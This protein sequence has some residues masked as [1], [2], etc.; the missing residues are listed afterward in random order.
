MTATGMSKRNSF[1]VT[2]GTLRRDAASYVQREAD[3]LLYDGLKQNKFCYVLTWRQMG[4]SS[5]MVRSGDP[6]RL[7]SRANSHRWRQHRDF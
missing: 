4:K 2:G 5:L 3:D 7:R 1:Y 6:W